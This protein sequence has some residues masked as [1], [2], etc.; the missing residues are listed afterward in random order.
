MRRFITV[1][2]ALA[3]IVLLAG[4]AW[5]EANL[6]LKSARQTSTYYAFAVGIANSIMKGAPE[7]KVT[8]ESS[9]GSMVNVKDSIKR[10]DYL[11]TSPPILIGSALQGKGK[12]TEKGYDQIRSLW[13][14]P[15][16]VMHWVVTEESGV[17]SLSE[18][19]GKKFIPGGAGS[20]GA[21]FTKQVLEVVGVADK[22]DLQT[23][24]LNEGVQ[25][26]KN[27]RAVGFSTASSP[28]AALVT[29][30]S[31]SMPVRLLELPDEPYTKVSKRFARYV[32]PKG[33]YKGVDTDVKT[34]SLQVGL[35]T[36]AS[37]PDET[38]YQITKAFWENRQV[39][40]KSH[41]AM[42]LLK[43]DELNSMVAK[44]HPGALKYYQEIGFK[45]SDELK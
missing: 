3:L 26:V 29:E 45:I 9:P 37:L 14:I 44:I 35:Y 19:A 1:I 16:L 43:M 42:K 10:K 31:A 36:T 41:P 2:T 23:V 7:V 21:R 30:I 17:K 13:P 5:A 28:P 24:D 18:L 25:A 20:A 34:I 12:F 6:A 4:S 11:F 39:W 22:V 15:G 32:I 38:A 33:T 40:E 8:V 27:R